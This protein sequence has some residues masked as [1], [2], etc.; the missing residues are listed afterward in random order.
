MVTAA[1]SAEIR[2]KLQVLMTLIVVSEFMFDA[3]VDNSDQKRTH[4]PVS[5]DTGNGGKGLPRQAAA[6]QLRQPAVKILP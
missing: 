5:V 1:V 6:P 2:Q 3:Q 4:A